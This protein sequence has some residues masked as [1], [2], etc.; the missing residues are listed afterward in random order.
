MADLD[1]NP[2]SVKRGSHTYY[3]LYPLDYELK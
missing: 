3:E 2:S 1:G